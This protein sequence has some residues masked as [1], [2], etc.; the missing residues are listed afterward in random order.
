M[1][2]EITRRLARRHHADDRPARCAAGRPPG[3]SA[4]NALIADPEDVVNFTV[5][6]FNMTPISPNTIPER[7]SSA[8]TPAIPT[9][10]CSMTRWGASPRSSRPPPRRAP[11]ASSRP[12]SWT[13]HRFPRAS[14]PHRRGR[15]GPR[16]SGTTPRLGRLSRSFYAAR[17]CPAG[18]IFV[19]CPPACR[20]TPPNRP[21]SRHCLAGARVLTACATMLAGA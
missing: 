18:I 3:D 7:V 20:I 8:S 10:P 17:L 14:L 5:G 2:V 12:C 21:N 4:L 13:R 11:R 15:G 6:R 16:P 9:G 19:P 1:N